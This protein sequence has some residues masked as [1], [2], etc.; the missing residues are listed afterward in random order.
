[1]DT[2]MPGVRSDEHF[3]VGLHQNSTRCIL[4]KCE[5]NWNY[6]IMKRVTM[7]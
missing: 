6:I 3:I 1:M 7:T 2:Y 5:A 4:A